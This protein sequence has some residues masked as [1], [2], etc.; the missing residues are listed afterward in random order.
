MYC[1]YATDPRMR[2]NLGI[3]RRLAPL[4]DNGRRQIELL[5]SLLFTLPGTPDPLLRRRDRHGRQHLPRRPQRRPHPDAVDAATATPASRAADPRASTSPLIVDPVY[6]YQAINVE[7]QQR[8]PTSLLNWMRRLIAV[9]KKTRVFGRGTLRFLRPAN[10]SVLAYV[11]SHE[12]ETVLAVHNLSARP[13]RSSSTCAR[14]P[15][16]PGRD[17]RRE[18][19]PGHRTGPTSSAWGRTATTGS[20]CSRPFPISSSMASS[21]PRSDAAAVVRHLSEAG[22]PALHAFIERQRWFAGKARGLRT[23]RVEDWSALGEDPPLVLLLVRADETRYF[24]PV[25]LGPAPADSARTIGPLGGLTLFD[26]HWH[27]SFGTSLLD[28]IRSQRA[29]ASASGSFRCAPVGPWDH[30]S[31]VISF[32]RNIIRSNR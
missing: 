31:W 11:R 16:H 8:T 3:R 14:G 26:A 13:S 4:M 5:N 32:C 15:A 25:A 12:G 7:A 2:L 17:A 6:G 28:A 30:A 19:V 21:T 10:D 27:P 24:V 22:A 9:R 18:P 1:E 20:G 29:F 23:V